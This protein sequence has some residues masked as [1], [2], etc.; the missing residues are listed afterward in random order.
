MRT[1]S[2]Y[3]PYGRKPK[4]IQN[5]AWDMLAGR[6]DP[7]CKD[8]GGDIVLTDV[9]GQYSGQCMSCRDKMQRYI[10]QP[11]IDE[12]EVNGHSA[13]I[14]EDTLDDMLERGE[15]YKERLARANLTKRRKNQR[16]R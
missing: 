4:A 1:S 13:Q 9:E 7:E 14:G 12:R 16:K 11:P 2:G 10:D 5:R 8:C 6:G 3:V 15:G